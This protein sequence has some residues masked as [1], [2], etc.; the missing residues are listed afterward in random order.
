MAEDSDSTKERGIVF[1]LV[2]VVFATVCGGMRNEHSGRDGL[3]LQIG[4][5]ISVFFFFHYYFFFFLRC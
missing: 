1:F 4:V 2:A 5:V 3:H